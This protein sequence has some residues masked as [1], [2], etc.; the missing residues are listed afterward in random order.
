VPGLLVEQAQHY[1]A[2]FL[3]SLPSELRASE[4][5]QR[6]TAVAEV[7]HELWH[8]LLCGEAAE[9]P[10]LGR[11][12]DEEAPK[13]DSDLALGLEAP[14]CRTHRWDGAAEHSGGL[15]G[16]EVVP[17]TGREVRDVVSGARHGR[18]LHKI[19]KYIAS[20]K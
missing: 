19:T 2:D 3:G 17:A 15:P 18:Y 16:G 4:D 9:A 8:E 1:L 12:D 13:R 11:D 6:L 5:G 10:V 14:Q 7:L 20:C